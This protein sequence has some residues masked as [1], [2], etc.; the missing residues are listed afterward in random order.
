MD[1]REQR[2]S[3]SSSTSGCEINQE[4]EYHDDGLPDLVL[5]T[6]DAPSSE[7]S[8]VD[9]ILSMTGERRAVSVSDLSQDSSKD[10]E[11]FE[12]FE[13]EAHAER[14]NLGFRVTYTDHR[15]VY[16]PPKPSYA[17]KVYLSYLCLM[18]DEEEVTKEDSKDAASR[19][20]YDAL[21]SPEKMKFLKAE[22]RA[23]L[24]QFAKLNGRQ[25]ELQRRAWIDELQVLEEDLSILRDKLS[26]ARQKRSR[27]RQ[28]IGKARVQT[29]RESW[30]Q[31]TS[32]FGEKL[33]LFGEKTECKA[34]E[35]EQ[36]LGKMAKKSVQHLRSVVNAH[37]VEECEQE[38]ES[39]EKRNCK[40]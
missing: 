16:V 40:E 34:A 23:V 9:L 27:L 12:T 5:Q 29:I 20:G 30:N 7:D 8:V 32:E 17:S 22:R 35:L 18:P 24:E 1:I 37:N 6:Q 38:S 3:C 11:D 2:H 36:T 26:Q 19:L 14:K 13:E 39:K 10:E 4:D 21:L 25:Q 15:K 28:N 31:V 33:M